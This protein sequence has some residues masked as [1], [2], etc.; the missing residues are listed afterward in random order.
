MARSPRITPGRIILWGPGGDRVVHWALFDQKSLWGK[1]YVELFT[2]LPR[3]A[4]NTHTHTQCEGM[5]RDDIISGLSTAAVQ[6]WLW[7]S[8]Q[9]LLYL[10]D[11]TSGAQ[12]IPLFSFYKRI[13]APWYCCP[14]R[15]S[16]GQMIGRNY[17]HLIFLDP[18]LLL[19]SSPLG[20]FPPFP[21]PLLP[22]YPYFFL[23]SPLF[24]SVFHSFP[25]LFSSRSSHLLW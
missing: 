10:V 24:C 20:Y 12:I 25:L 5:Q 11:R 2:W 15:G 3:N 13:L 21:S 7:I 6:P 16:H 4:G 19:F 22:C 18:H 14:L 8:S 17:I 9:A 23:S 1:D